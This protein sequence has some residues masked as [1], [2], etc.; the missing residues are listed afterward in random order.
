MRAEIN[1]A[2]KKVYICHVACSS[3]SFTKSSE[4]NE[5]PR[6]VSHNNHDRYDWGQMK[7]PQTW[8]KIPRLL[9]LGEDRCFPPGIRIPDY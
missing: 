1:E 4:L 8:D 9:A 2:E 7:K 6:G 5:V 3:L